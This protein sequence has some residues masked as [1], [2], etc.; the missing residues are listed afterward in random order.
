[1][2]AVVTLLL[3]G[4]NKAIILLRGIVRGSLSVVGVRNS[5]VWAIIIISVIMRIVERGVVVIIRGVLI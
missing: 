3:R 5:V 1:M 4:R 2:I